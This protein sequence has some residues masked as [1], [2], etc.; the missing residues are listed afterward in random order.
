M[1]ITV[2]LPDDIARQMIP[3]GRDPARAALEDMAVEA[4]RAHRVT[5]H[6]LATLL[7]L[8]RYELDG[9]LKQRGVWLDYST[10]DL[11]REVE[12]GQQLW[13]KRQQELAASS[14]TKLAGLLSSW[15]P[16]SKKDRMPA[17]D[18]PPKP[19]EI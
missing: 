18:E 9:F 6:Q 4:Y 15:K 7:G 1:Q 13:K 3:A 10:G 8:D 17:I 14:R 12:L 16:L 11:Q 5:E 19:L 2:E